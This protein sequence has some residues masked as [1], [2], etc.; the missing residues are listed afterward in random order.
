MRAA[1]ASSLAGLLAACAPAGPPSAP[2]FAG[3]TYT[4]ASIAAVPTSA[5]AAQLLAPAEAAMVEG[6]WISEPAYGGDPLDGARFQTRPRPLAEDICGRD[7]VYVVMVK[8]DHRDRSADPPVRP[9]RLIRWTNLALSRNCAALPGLRFARIGYRHVDRPGAGPRL[10]VAD[11]IAILRWLA[12]ARAA[13]AGV[14]PLPFRLRCDTSGAP[15]SRPSGFCPADI[16]ALLAG[17]PAHQAITID[18][19]PFR[20]NT[21]C[22]PPDPET[23]DSIEIASGDPRNYVWEVRLRGMG[24]DQA[25][26][27]LTQQFPRDQM[28]C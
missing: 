10:A 28:R 5:L 12:F 6:H 9:E 1:I 21:L 7:E 26:I 24:T 23:G 17:L 3:P 11:G 20:T 22:G 13:A 14:G 8:T 25:E 15:H 16:R 18:R 27:T 4:R 19:A 2:P